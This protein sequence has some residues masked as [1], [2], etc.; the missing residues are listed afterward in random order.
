VD[1]GRNN[2]KSFLNNYFNFRFEYFMI[3][4]Y[5]QVCSRYQHAVFREAVN[6]GRDNYNLKKISQTKLCSGFKDVLVSIYC[7]VC[8]RYHHAVFR[9]AAS[10]GRDFR[11]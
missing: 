9:E 3:S 2:S 5:F 6:A 10:A 11:F 4:I 8:S 1:A 7:Q